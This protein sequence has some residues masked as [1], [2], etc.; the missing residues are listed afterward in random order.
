MR[1]YSSFVVRRWQLEPAGERVQVEHMQSGKRAT[2]ESLTTA[3]KWMESVSL[4][5]DHG[6]PLDAESEEVDQP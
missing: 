4:A 3:A 6:V 2:V 5:T 1:Q